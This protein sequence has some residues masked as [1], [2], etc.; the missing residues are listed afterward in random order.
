MLL[1]LLGKTCSGKDTIAKELAMKYGFHRI[2]TTTSRP[3]RKDEIQ[4]IDY[5]FVSENE[6]KEKIEEGY[7]VE[8]QTYET[9]SGKWYYGTTYKSLE[10]IKDNERY[11]IILTPN[12]YKE[13]IKKVSI[14][15]KLV[16]VYANNST[17]TNRLKKRKDKNDSIQRRIERDNE[18]FK[19]VET[20][21]DRIVYNNDTDNLD[22][23]IEKI[24]MCLE[25]NFG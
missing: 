8:Y 18:D 7:F 14:H 4:D 24:I 11:V 9:T 13:L 12:G 3:M 16:Y 25:G 21:V 2:T 23:V 1:I 6:F 20:I 22:Y 15:H 19:G 10:N 17:I 5:H